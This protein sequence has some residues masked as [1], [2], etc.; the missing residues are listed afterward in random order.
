[1]PAAQQKKK[2]HAVREI[3]AIFTHF[4]YSPVILA[5]LW[6]RV[7]GLVV[8]IFLAV[9]LILSHLTFPRES[10]DPANDFLR[11]LMLM[12]IGLV[13]S[14]KYEECKGGGESEGE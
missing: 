12:A 11:I 7:K 6:W 9:L 3:G 2:F 10:V 8:T 1:M 13:V 5:A 4:F 14:V